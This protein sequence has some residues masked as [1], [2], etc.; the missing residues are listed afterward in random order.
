MKKTPSNLAQKYSE[1]PHKR[2]CS[3]RF[4]K[5]SFHH[6]RK[7]LPFKFNKSGLEFKKKINILVYPGLL[8]SKFPKK[9]QSARLFRSARLLGTSEY[10]LLPLAAQTTQTEEF[11]LR[12]VAYRPTVYKTGVS[13]K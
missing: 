10:S 12:N 13:T 7:F 3:L 2:A 8:I 6:T 5:Y 1:V 11:V 4:F 9:C